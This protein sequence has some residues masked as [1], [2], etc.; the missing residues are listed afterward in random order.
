MPLV[1]REITQHLVNRYLR[2]A[3]QR[4]SRFVATRWGAQVG[5]TYVGGYPKSGTTW[6]SQLVGNYLGLPVVAGSLLPI[7]HRCVLHQHWDHQ[8][9]LDREVYVI[10]DGRDVMVS[11]YHNLMKNVIASREKRRSYG[12]LSAVERALIDRVDWAVDHERRFERILGVGYEPWNLSANLPRFIEA[13]LT[14]PFLPVVT[15]PWHE[16]V[17]SWRAAGR[18]TTFVRYEDLLSDTGAALAKVI[19]GMQGEPADRALVALA[20]DRCSFARQTGRAQGTEDR[21]KFA[22]KGI[23]GDWR[24]AF[25]AE[26]RLVFHRIA[27]E[28]LVELGYERDDVWVQRAA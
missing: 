1:R 26:A 12:R 13:E 3:S 9:A 25:S 14:E 24:R 23:A 4:G 18:R 21:S 2:L 6:A 17:R 20:V 15:R 11:L 19:E 8:P 27:G 7:G 28:L 16:H 10:R 5:F 22:R